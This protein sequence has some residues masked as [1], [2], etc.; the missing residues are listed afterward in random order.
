MEPGDSLA[1]YY[2]RFRALLSGV[3]EAYN[4]RAKVE[5]PDS[6]Y[7]DVQL[8][9][10]FTIG[11]NS[12]YSAYKQY[13]EDGLKDWPQSLVDAFSEAAKF[14]PRT[15]GS[16]NPDD[17]GRAN[18]FA[19]RGRGR[20]RGRGRSSGRGRN[21]DNRRGEYG[22]LTGSTSGG[23]SEYGTRKGACHTCGE[24][25]HYSFECKAGNNVNNSKAGASTAQSDSSGHGKGK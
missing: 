11:L 2:Q 18:A 23:P 15:A 12:S 1:F 22:E 17:V 6:S 13:Y 8:A 19:M 25:G 16:G 9:L 10:R 14:K 3:Q 20:G 7:R 5:P 24:S 4:S 21:S